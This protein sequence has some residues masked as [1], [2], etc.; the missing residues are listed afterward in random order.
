MNIRL[1]VLELLYMHW[2]T[3]KDGERERETDRQTQILGRKSCFNMRPHRDGNMRE[4]ARKICA[5]KNL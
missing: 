5:Y 3:Q 2:E 1:V 4:N